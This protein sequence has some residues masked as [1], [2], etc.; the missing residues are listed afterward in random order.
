MIAALILSLLSFLGA[1]KHHEC[2]CVWHE[3]SVLCIVIVAAEL[4]Y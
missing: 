2:L 3:V 4:T 1:A